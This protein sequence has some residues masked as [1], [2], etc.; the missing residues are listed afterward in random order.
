M[1]GLSQSSLF[2]GSNNHTPA[3]TVIQTPSSVVTPAADTTP[4]TNHCKFDIFDMKLLH[5]FSSQVSLTFAEDAK[6]LN[7]WRHQVPS[8]AFQHSFLLDCVLSLSAFH[9][10][11]K[12]PEDH[13]EALAK[14]DE[15]YCRALPAVI[16]ALSDI[17]DDSISP[18]WVA[19]MTLCFRFLARGPHAGDYLLFNDAED[20]PSEW[21][22]LLRGVRSIIESGRSVA[23]TLIEQS[24]TD[25]S[26]P[27]TD[28]QPPMR[29]ARVNFDEPL[30]RLKTFADT[31]AAE[32][33]VFDSYQ[34]A[35]TLLERSFRDAYEDD[36]NELPRLQSSHVFAWMYRLSDAFLASLA[37]RRPLA[38]VIYAHYLVLF[39]ELS[40]FWVIEGW[41][42]HILNG[43]EQH[44]HPSFA[45]WLVWPKTQLSDRGTDSSLS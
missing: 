27:L 15:H 23:F 32:S 36:G 29:R 13:D 38:L 34:N 14:A 41:I 30:S 6:T 11:R 37:E 35:V 42:L 17:N 12:S 8:T 45:H 22:R 40:H 44:V 18:L 31:M 4:R 1:S 16:R 28:L 43:I 33:A 9:L 2:D 21:C 24:P 39:H 25:E 7:F 20:E 19:S 26:V 3:S 5:H 10:A